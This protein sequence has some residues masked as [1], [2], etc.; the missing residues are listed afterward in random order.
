[1]LRKTALTGLVFSLLLVCG[2]DL[3]AQERKGFIIGFGIGAGLTTWKVSVDGLAFE[4]ERETKGSLA[5]DFKIGAQV[6]PAVQVYYLSR[7]QFF[8]GSD[9]IDVIVSGVSAIGVTYVLPS[10]PQIQL[11]GGVGL[12]SWNEIVVASCCSTVSATGFGLTGGFGYE[13]ADLWLL[14]ISVTYG[15]PSDSGVDFDMFQAR[16]GISILSH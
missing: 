2:Q 7:V 3:G 11:S 9:F 8:G 13:F 1:M 5:T 12:S 10:S 4:S 16:A 6:S 15:M 14:D